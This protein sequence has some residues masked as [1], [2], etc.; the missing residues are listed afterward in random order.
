MTERVTEQ[1]GSPPALRAVV[2]GE[3]LVDVV[4][5]SDGSVSEHPGGSPLNVAYGLARLGADVVLVTR[6][7][8]DEHGAAVRAHLGS[9]GVRLPDGAVDDGSTSLAHAHLDAEGRA[10]YE[11]DL[12]W[13]LPPVELPGDADVLHTGSIATALQPGAGAV[14]ALLESARGRVP[15]TFDPNVRAAFL[16]EP[17]QAREQVE[18]VV[19]LSDVVK[20]SD[21][22]LAWLA[23]GEDVVDV[24]R[25]WAAL[26]PALVVVTRGGEGAVGVTAAGALHEEPAPRIDVVDTVGAGDAF[27]SGLLDALA[28]EGV[29]GA[30]AGRLRDLDGDALRRVVARAIRSASSTCTRAGANPPT[31]EQLDAFGS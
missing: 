22:D 23:P 8:D 27:M 3:A 2:V 15:V 6:L 11:F 28:L 18:Q 30:G 17:A 4:H 13:A 19:A 5:H 24:A 10:T 1:A 14:R 31:R 21:E 20:A 16:P 26:G 9:A 29:L 7:G 25:S 12:E